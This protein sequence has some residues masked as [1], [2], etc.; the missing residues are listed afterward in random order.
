LA[1]KVRLLGV[2]SDGQLSIEKENGEGENVVAGEIVMNG[3]FR[4]L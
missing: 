4:D 1:E 3:A 2:T